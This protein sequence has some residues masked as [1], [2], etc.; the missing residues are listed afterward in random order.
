MQGR[1]LMCQEHPFECQKNYAGIVTLRCNFDVQDLRRVLPEHLWKPDDVGMPSIGSRKEWGYQAVYE[2]DEDAYVLRRP[3]GEAGGTFGPTRWKDDMT[4]GQWREV[5]SSAL[6][7]D[8]AG[9]VAVGH[10]SDEET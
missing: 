8:E 6:H 2:R 1:L 9:D 7:R 4:L 3:E 10:E 5:F